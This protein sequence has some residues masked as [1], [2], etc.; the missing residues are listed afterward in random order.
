MQEIFI[1]R[2]GEAEHLLSGMVGGWTDSSLTSLGREQARKTGDRM[3]ELLN[4]REC[5]Y[6]CSDLSRAR[7]TAEIIG[8][9]LGKKPSV[10]FDLRELN[11]G[12]AANKSKEETEKLKKPITAPILDW[13]PFPEAESWNMLHR[14]VTKFMEKIR[15]DSLNTTLIVTHSNTANAIIHW[16]LEFTSDMIEKVSFDI[17]PCSITHLAITQWSNIKTIRKMNDT[18]HLLQFD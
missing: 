4:G 14:R 12:I 18:G 16:W 7:E 1:I 13:I 8:S 17:D 5:N 11:N 10:Q 3:K 6:Y 2:H 15:N 9:I